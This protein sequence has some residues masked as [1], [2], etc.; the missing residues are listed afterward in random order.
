MRKRLSALFILSVFLLSMIPMAFA[1]ETGTTEED[2]TSVDPLATTAKRVRIAQKTAV[3]TQV[4]AR[5]EGMNLSEKQTLAKAQLLKAR[6]RYELAK[7]HYQNIR[8]AYVTEKAKWT[9]VRATYKACKSNQSDSTECVKKKD[10]IKQKARPYLLHAADL[11]LKELE[12]MKEKVQ[13]SEDL[14]EEEMTKMVNELDEKI[15]EVE[16][17]KEVITNLDE[18]SSKE[19]INKAAKTIKDAWRKTKAV[20]KKHAGKLVNARLGNII[21]KT[22]MLEKRLYKTRDKL[23]A[24][25]LDVSTLD[26]MLGDFSEKLDTAAISYKKAREKWSEA[27]TP[28]EVDEVAKEIRELL[29]EAKEALKEARDMLRNI[30]KEIKTLNKGSLEVETADEEEEADDEEDDEEGSEE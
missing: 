28:E 19:E 7:E 23:E 3:A 20:M 22:E 29:T 14:S 17:A 21:L 9:T 2:D 5:L 10:E 1:E 16:A 25:G 4:K 12:L 26:D 8:A 13:S 11:V 24:K 30:V 15:Q 27:N 6:T 18:N